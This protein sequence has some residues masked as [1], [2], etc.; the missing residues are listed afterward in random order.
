MD[1]LVI[2]RSWLETVSNGAL[3]AFLVRIT[4]VCFTGQL[5]LLLLRRAPAAVRHLAATTT[6]A[7]LVLAPVFFAL[8]PAWP[9]LRIPIAP[10]PAAV[11][12]ATRSLAAPW[13]D[14]GAPVFASRT[15]V[16]RVPD[17]RTEPAR[18][19]R[20]RVAVL[21]DAARVAIARVTAP[22]TMP[23][24]LP[25]TLALLL[26]AVSEFLLVLCSISSLCAAWLARNA[27][28]VERS[29]IRAEMGAACRR[30]GLTHDVP[31]CVSG[32]LSVPV[33]VGI[34]RPR[35]LLPLVALDWP[36]E[37]RQAV[38]VHEL[39]HVARRD[40]I[41]QLVARIATALFWFHPLA[42][43]LA[44]VAHD[45]CERAADDTVLRSGVRASDYAEHLLAVARDAMRAPLPRAALAFARPSSLEA[46]LLAILKP[47]ARREPAARQGYL[48]AGLAVALFIL[49]LTS[50]RVVAS[51][52]ACAHV[53]P[54]A[55]RISA[56]PAGRTSGASAS[57]T[58]TSWSF[59]QT[60][61]E[62]KHSKCTTSTQCTSPATVTSTATATPAGFDM[63]GNPA[64]S[65]SGEKW[66]DLA[67]E[68]YGARRFVD[69]AEA[70]EYAARQGYRTSTAWYNSACSWSL[71]GQRDA[72]LGA[73]LQ[74]LDSGFDDLEQVQTDDD[75]AAIRSDGRYQLLLERAMRSEKGQQKRAAARSEFD[76][77]QASGKSDA[78]E[79]RATGLTLLRSGE[80][81]RAAEAFQAEFALDSSASGLYNVACAQARGNH[82]AAALAT[83]QRAVLLGF[84]DSKDIASDADL[85]SLH[86]DPAFD[87]TLRLADDLSLFSNGRG[88][89]DTHAW[90]RDLPR[91]ER[92][93]QE[94]PEAGRAWFNLGYAQLRVTNLDGSGR[95]FSRALELGYRTGTTSYNLACVAARRGDV[96]GAFR[97]LERAE[98]A[99]MEVGG[100][101]RGDAD[102]AAIRSDARYRLM[103][104]RWNAQRDRGDD[105]K[106][107][108]EKDK[109]KRKA[110][111][112]DT[113]T[114]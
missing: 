111:Q 99:G 1:P 16:T 74:A 8:L 14:T 43:A 71:A 40:G 7:A 13:R 45:E 82:A 26:L 67:H 30:V 21:G 20:S 92:V 85:V 94:F 108:S 35:L 112:G 59:V 63:H 37:R 56:Q 100:P 5:A 104:D 90:R 106:A 33:V 64:A 75:L 34:A 29:D 79:W 69:A 41:A 70:Y 80:P 103:L 88:D 42:W 93:T 18:T 81:D 113:G 107:K 50:L 11:A 73:L 78:S 68:R 95:S 86:A 114:P 83:L 48:W 39:A 47:D 9:A 65:R 98:S 44:R 12:F 110:T 3:L 22:V 55:E 23:L 32:H 31:L 49:P 24:R 62:T 102:L 19:P 51:P 87:R 61:S 72:A 10:P 54:A 91:F 28:E 77:L 101:M 53:E 66:Y 38:L 52:R 60:T 84:G 96:D 17:L 76:A 57:A 15:R 36:A 6:L 46:R 27:R 2:F 89:D 97:W 4:L 105:E 109:A 25:G 58:E